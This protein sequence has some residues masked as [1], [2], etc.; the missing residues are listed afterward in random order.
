MVARTQKKLEA[1]AQ[2][3]KD[4]YKVESRIIQYDFA[5]LDSVEEAER[6][7]KMLDEHTK[8]LDVGILVNNA[9]IAWLGIAHT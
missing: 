4:D 6:V 9:G 3:L 7:E 2:K 5:K 8:D 1:V